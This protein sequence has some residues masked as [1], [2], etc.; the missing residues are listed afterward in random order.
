MI[1]SQML[2]VLELGRS[3]IVSGIRSIL[4]WNA[5]FIDHLAWIIRTGESDPVVLTLG[6]VFGNTCS[7]KDVS[8]EPLSNRRNSRL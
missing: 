7:E 4:K 5:R 6:Q 3:Y 2:I 1:R 8:K